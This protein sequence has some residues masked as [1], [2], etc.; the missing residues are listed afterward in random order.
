MIDGASR[1][2][3]LWQVLFPLV[4]P[5]LAATSISSF[6]GA[7]NDFLFAKSFIISAVRYST[8]PMAPLVFFKPEQ[9]DWGG[10][11]AGSTV[12]PCRCWSSSSWRSADWSR[13]S[14]GR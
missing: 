13:A 10:I 14:R 4:L 11:M 5:G 7:W 3:F 9:Y 6:I 12:C 2:R 1:A 8:L